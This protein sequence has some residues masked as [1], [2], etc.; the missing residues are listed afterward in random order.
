MKY[1]PKSPFRAPNSPY[2]TATQQP[3]PGDVPFLPASGDSPCGASP[4]R[5]CQLV[6][7]PNLPKRNIDEHALVSICCQGAPHATLEFEF[8]AGYFQALRFKVLCRLD[9]KRKRGSR[10]VNGKVGFGIARGRGPIRGSFVL[11]QKFL[12]DI[13]F[14]QRTFE[15]SKNSGSVKN[16][17]WREA[18]ERSE[19]AGV[20]AEQFEAREVF[21]A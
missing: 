1:G 11:E 17:G 14:G 3:A 7:L 13:L 4:Q 10:M 21:V 19:D 16:D 20:D 5:L 2:S 9:L 12:R 8:F 15:L 18:G 6:D